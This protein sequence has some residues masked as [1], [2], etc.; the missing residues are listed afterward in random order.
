MQD[1]SLHRKHFY[2]QTLLH[3]KLLH[4][5]LLPTEVFTHRRFYTQTL[6]HTEAFTYRSFYTQKLLHTNTFTHRRFYTQ[7]LWHTDAF[8]HRRFYTQTLLH[9]EAF[10][11]RRFYTQALVHTNTFTQTLLHTNAFTR[12]RFYTQKPLHTITC[13]H[14]RFYTQA[15]P[16]THSEVIVVVATSA[17]PCCNS[18]SFSDISGWSEPRV[19][20]Y[21]GQARYESRT[22][23]CAD[24]LHALT[25]KRNT[26]L[27]LKLANI[28]RFYQ[29]LAAKHRIEWLPHTDIPSSEAKAFNALIP[30]LRTWRRK[31]STPPSVKPCCNSRSFSDLSGWSEPRVTTYRG[32][33][34]YKSRTKSCAD[35]L[36]ALTNKR[37]TSLQLKLANIL[38]F[39]QKLAAKHR[40]TA[41]HWWQ[42]AAGLQ[43]LQRQAPQPPKEA[44]EMLTVMFARTVQGGAGSSLVSMETQY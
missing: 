26:S 20:T 9:T 35:Q 5:K 1:N 6:L 7:T 29:K 15:G 39:Y 37:N 43:N 14:R 38:R 8:T 4:T 10:T 18:R 30:S 33:A 16:C 17:I 41:T 12:I 2:T 19:T 32:Q 11:H 40:M 23:S 24:Q 25:N 34:R 36:H 21:R 31:G 44:L 22:K 3:T 28:L 13:T 27:Q 42:H